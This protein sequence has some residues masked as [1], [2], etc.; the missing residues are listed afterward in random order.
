[1]NRSVKHILVAVLFQSMTV[2]VFAQVQTTS[3][4][5][6]VVAG[7]GTATSVGY[8]ILVATNPL[9]PFSVLASRADGSSSSFASMSFPTGGLRASASSGFG[10]S[11]VYATSLA[12]IFDTVS[13][14]GPIPVPAIGE[15]RL[16]VTGVIS[17]NFVPPPDL[18]SSGNAGT[19]GA[20][21]AAGNLALGQFPNVTQSFV[22]NSC[23]GITGACS[24][25]V[26]F[27]QT[28]I[29]PFTVTATSRNIVINA[30]LGA[31]A[32]NGSVV[33]FANTANLSITLPPGLGF[34]SNTGLLSAV[35]EPTSAAMLITGFAVLAG[36]VQRRRSVSLG[37]T[38]QP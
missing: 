17:G 33:N 25:G 4:G 24:V 22:G 13:I 21:L 28:L 35:P 16:S 19:A 31:T 37:K 8:N 20:T 14:T 36:V 1:M 7:Q 18:G 26:A 10:P 15:A 5:Y 29:V 23:V 12:Y 30:T 6:V 3:A 9:Q 38:Q 2:A 32:Y 11:A 34:T 27:S